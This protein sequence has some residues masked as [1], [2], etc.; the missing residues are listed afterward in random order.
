MFCLCICLWDTCIYHL[1]V[2]SVYEIHVYII[3]MF[4]LCICLWDTCIYH[5]GVLSDFRNVPPCTVYLS[6]ITAVFFLNGL[7]VVFLKKTCI[8]ISYFRFQLRLPLSR[9]AVTWTE[10]CRYSVKHKTINQSFVG[11]GLWSIFLYTLK[12]YS[13]PILNPNTFNMLNIYLPVSR[14]TEPLWNFG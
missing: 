10:C 7:G 6:I 13:K 3:W 1:G 12:C 11:E 5:L 8:I 2:L 14:N 4:C 9:T